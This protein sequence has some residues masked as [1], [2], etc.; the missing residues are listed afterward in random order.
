MIKNIKIK[1]GQGDNLV[2][3]TEEIR[4]LVSES[5]VQEGV[6]VLFAPHTTAALTINSGMDPNT[7]VDIVEEVGR[8]VPTRVNFKHQYDTPTDAAGHIKSVLIGNSLSLII[9]GGELLLGHSQ[10]VLFCEFDGPRL[11]TVVARIMSE[12]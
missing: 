11:R 2:N 5:G 7:I 6:C 4:N 9:T 8:L 3:I 1:T 12:E 10:S